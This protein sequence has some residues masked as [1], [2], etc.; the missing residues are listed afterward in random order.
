MNKPIDQLKGTLRELKNELASLDSLDI[1]TRELLEG[2][3]HEIEG[4]L[5][6]E[7]GDEDQEKWSHSGLKDA[8]ER[9]ETSHPTLTGILSRLVDALGQMGI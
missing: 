3:V 8:I 1:E 5:R 7:T 2:A 6:R 9:F 4:K